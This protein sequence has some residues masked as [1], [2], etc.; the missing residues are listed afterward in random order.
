MPMFK[1]G[2]RCFLSVTGL[3]VAVGLT[4]GSLCIASGFRANA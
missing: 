4:L 3:A 2:R 1:Q